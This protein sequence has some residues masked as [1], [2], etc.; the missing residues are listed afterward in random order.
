VRVEITKRDDGAGLLRC[1]RDDGSVVW[2]KQSARHAPH[3]ALHDLTHFAVETTLGS[4]SGFFGLLAQG[5]EM[6]DV[7]GKGARGHLQAEATQVER[8][9]GIFDA[10]RT[11]GTTWTS[12][13]FDHLLS[14]EDI[15]RVRDCRDEL[16]RRWFALPKGEPLQLEFN[17]TCVPPRSKLANS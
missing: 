15:S 6:V 10:E 16:F 12:E 1:I 9:V 11:S 8:I 17:L 13:E 3:F 2:Q 5:W 4:R 7:T 14:D